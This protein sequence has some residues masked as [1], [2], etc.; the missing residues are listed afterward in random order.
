MNFALSKY[1]VDMVVGNLLNNKN[2]I[3]VV[4]NPALLA[5]LKEATE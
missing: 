2:W 1:N 3:K 4:Y 5:D